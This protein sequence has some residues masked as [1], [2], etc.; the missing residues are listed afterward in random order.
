VLAVAPQCVKHS[1]GIPKTILFDEPFIKPSFYKME[2]WE[3][4]REKKKME[5]RV[6][7]KLKLCK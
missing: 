7:T 4:E 2:F 6:F 1:T 3:R 5:A